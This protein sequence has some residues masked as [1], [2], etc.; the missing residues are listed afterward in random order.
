ME[1]TFATKRY[2]FHELHRS[3]PAA[4][5]LW[6]WMKD[7]YDSKGTLCYVYRQQVRKFIEITNYLHYSPVRGI[8][9][10]IM[11][12]HG[13]PIQLP[14]LVELGVVC[15]VHCI[16]VRR[17]QLFRLSI[18]NTRGPA[19]QISLWVTHAASAD[20]LNEE[21]HSDGVDYS[22]WKP[23]SR[24]KSV[25]M[26]LMPRQ[27]LQIKP[28]WLLPKD[29]KN[30]SESVLLPAYQPRAGCLHDSCEPDIK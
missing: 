14:S 24:S 5:E 4:S 28:L 30:V 17:E 7:G 29:S 10:N 18:P 26:P 6:G 23:S 12:S 19:S 13:V 3:L 20:Y 22:R 27:P 9:G 25:A 2:R 1:K 15:G 21:T 11:T 8:S 16:P